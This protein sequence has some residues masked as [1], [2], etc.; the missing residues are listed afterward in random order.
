[1]PASTSAYSVVIIGAGVSG[2]CMGIR[3][4]DQG[5][6]DFLIL[7]RAPAVGG[8][9][10]DNTY[11]GACC[12][13]PSLLY[14]YSF[15]PR[16]DWSRLYAPHDEI[17]AYLEHCV[18]RYGLGPRLRLGAT[19]ERAD[20]IAPERCW[21][22]RLQ[23]GSELSARALVSGLG[24]L[25][26]PHIP[27]FPGRDAFAGESFHSARWNHAIDLTGKRVAVIGSA[28][29]AL[30]F[31]PEVARRAS[32]LHVYQRSANYVLP[33]NDR[34]FS[35]R[36]KSL[37]A[38]FPSLQRL[39]RLFIYLRLELLMYPL[40]RA[41]S[42]LIRRFWEWACRRY[43]EQEIDDP[44]LR[45]KLT[46]DYPAGCKRVLV[47]DNY[48]AA[49]RRDHVELVTSPIT[50]MDAAGIVT[51]D[52][53]ARPV[54]VVIYGT[55]FRASDMLAA[56]DFHGENGRRLSEVWRGGAEAYRGVCVAGFPNFFMLYGPNTN[57]G[58]NSIIFM[59]ERQCDY[60][61]ACIDKL[62]GHDL[63]SLTVNEDAMW[64]WNERLQAQMKDT[65]WV[66]S[67]ESWYKNAA[68][69]VTNN[70][71][72]STLAYWWQMRYPDFADFEM[73]A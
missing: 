67:C 62:L 63:G 73:R 60:A 33:R 16:P 31:I 14:S 8:T 10:H 65:V 69:K 46:P 19:V 56:V 71:P 66:A 35:A 44:V 32:Q 1:M 55:G 7:E 2:I 27:D 6:E 50:G 21:R 41:N 45:A 11:P 53:Q 39:R 54:D 25:N 49:F 48:Y 68:G 23:D 20:W 29:S 24:Q 43:L 38:R 30:Q 47:S 12:D 22:I 34:A 18:D 17:R 52:G 72:R 61:A 13:V 51:E 59:V 42:R 4:R 70:W 36:E 9:W 15:E 3:L 26:L 40:M 5:I 64:A 37:F 28:A 58:S 57:L